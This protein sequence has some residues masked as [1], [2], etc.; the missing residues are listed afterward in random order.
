LLHPGAPGGLKTRW[1][2]ERKT[3]GSGSKFIRIIIDIFGSQFLIF[4]QHAI[5]GKF[6]ADDFA[7]VTI[8]TLPLL[9]DQGG[10]IPFF[11]KFRGFLED[12]VG[13]K[14]DAKPATLAAVFDDMQFPNRYGVGR[15]I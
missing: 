15:C 7:E 3:G 6:R 13:A 10:V 2:W 9:G 11:I 12:L 1:G 5:D 8:H 4:F 14:F